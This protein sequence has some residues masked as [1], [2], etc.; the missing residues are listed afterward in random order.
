M[1]TNLRLPVTLTCE[2][3]GKSAKVIARPPNILGGIWIISERARRAACARMDADWRDTNPKITGTATVR[4]IDIDG[5][6][7][8]TIYTKD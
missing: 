7:T 4:A 6:H 3:T 2:R 8:F 1:T 5:Y